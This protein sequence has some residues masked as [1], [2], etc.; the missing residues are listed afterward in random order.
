MTSRER[1]VFGILCVVVIPAVVL[2]IDVAFY[3]GMKGWTYYVR[4]DGVAAFWPAVLMFGALFF[5]LAAGLFAN[6]MFDLWSALASTRWRVADGRVTDCTVEVHEYT[7]RGWIG[8]ETYQEYKP[9]I[10]YA[11]EV[12]GATYTNDLTA[13]GLSSF[14]SR[15]EAE[16]MLRGYPKGGTVRVHYDPDDPATSVLQSTGGWAF[17]ALGLALACALTPFMIAVM[18][19]RS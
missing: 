8:W 13:F 12:A 7:R 5:P 4:R 6:A 2:A 18:I 1:R 10:A 15:E 11:Y 3:V 16:G 14:E 19:V 17:K 9:K